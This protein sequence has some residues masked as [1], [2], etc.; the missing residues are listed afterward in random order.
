MKRGFDSELGSGVS[1]DNQFVVEVKTNELG[2]KPG[3]PKGRYPNAIKQALGL[4]LYLLSRIN[5]ETKLLVLTDRPLYDLCSRDMDGL[6][7]P[8]TQIVYCSAD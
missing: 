7:A 4:D 3:Q 8:D 6:L 5:A 1:P 2:A